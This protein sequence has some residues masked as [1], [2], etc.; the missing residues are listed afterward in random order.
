VL[1]FHLLIGC[2]K[3]IILMSSR[4]FHNWYGKTIPKCYLGLYICGI[5]TKKL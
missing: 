2:S 5:Y 1:E 3:I 4:G